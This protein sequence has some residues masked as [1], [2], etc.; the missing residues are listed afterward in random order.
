MSAALLLAGIAEPH[1]RVVL[2]LMRGARRDLVQVADG[3]ER[4]VR[5]DV[6]ALLADR[7]LE[8]ADRAWRYF[9]Y[10]EAELLLAP[11]RDNLEHAEA[12]PAALRAR[13]VAAHAAS[14]IFA[15]WDR[16]D[17]AA[18]LELWADL[19]TAAQAE[20]TDFARPLRCLASGDRAKR[21]SLILLDL[22]HNAQRRADRG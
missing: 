15:A 9:G 17:H 1:A 12:I 16:F 3:T 18:A 5:I 8:R 22:W 19:P 7:Q 10:A 14:R 2:Q 11:A 6:D 4:P 20:L 13:L 21:E